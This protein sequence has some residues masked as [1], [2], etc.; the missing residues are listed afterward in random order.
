ME[1]QWNRG[2]EVRKTPLTSDP[3][4]QD[5]KISALIVSSQLSLQSTRVGLWPKKKKTTTK[6]S[7]GSKR[8][9][10]CSVWFYFIKFKLILNTLSQKIR[11]YNRWRPLET[12]TINARPCDLHRSADWCRGVTCI[13]VCANVQELEDG[14]GPWR[15]CGPVYVH[16][17]TLTAN[18]TRQRHEEKMRKE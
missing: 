14:H 8:S 11:I 18:K 13:L 10:N 16:N 1:R 2:S 9:R 7:D 12:T 17:T 5:N 6:W 4:W 3:L 15:C